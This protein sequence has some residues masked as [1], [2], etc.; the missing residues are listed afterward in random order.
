MINAQ[1]DLTVEGFE[2]PVLFEGEAPSPE[3]T[4]PIQTT[5]GDTLESPQGD[6]QMPDFSGVDLSGGEDGTPFD[7]PDG[8]GGTGQE[9]L[10]PDGISLEGVEGDR[11]GEGVTG[12]LVNTGYLDRTDKLSLWLRPSNDLE[13]APLND[14]QAS[15]LQTAVKGAAIGGKVGTILAPIPGVGTSLGTAIGTGVGLAIGIFR[16][17]DREPASIR[18][19]DEHLPM[20][21]GQLVGPENIVTERMVNA[22]GIRVT[23]PLPREAIELLTE[24]IRDTLTE[25]SKADGGR[26]RIADVADA[27]VLSREAPSVAAGAL[28]PSEIVRF[29][30][31][32]QRNAQPQAP[33]GTGAAILGIGA[34][35]AF[36]FT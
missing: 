26:G 5:A 10:F 8:I 34:L 16:G 19:G 2:P 28:R 31:L 24:T 20:I 11:A 9:Q 1:F 27:L 12:I 13:I 22:K 18:L 14:K 29:T 15:T 6:F 4:Q 25:I 17:S 30:I 35:A 32:D 23:E 33:A 36:L 21:L 7:I 3:P